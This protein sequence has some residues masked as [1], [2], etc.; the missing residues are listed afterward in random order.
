MTRATA[1]ADV[2]DA[3]VT[4]WKAMDGDVEVFD[5]LEPGDETSQTYLIVGVE[6]PWQADQ[7]IDAATSEQDFP[8][9]TYQVRDERLSVRCVVVSWTGDRVLAPARQAAVAAL[10]AAAAA[11]L[12]DITLGGAVLQVTAISGIALR[13]SYN[14]DG[15]VVN[16]P[17]TIECQARLA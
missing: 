17:F 2:I 8:L 5:G 13:Q 10:D 3:L 9:L 14:A 1:L 15:V 7:N 12:A 16:I 4:T 11:L 6:D